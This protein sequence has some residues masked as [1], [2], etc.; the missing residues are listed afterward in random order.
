[1]VPD[2]AVRTVGVPV[3]AAMSVTWWSVK[4]KSECRCHQFNVQ[5][6]RC[7][8]DEEFGLITIRFY[9]CKDGPESDVVVDLV[10]GEDN[11]HVVG[12]GPLLVRQT[13]AADCSYQLIRG[14]GTVI[15]LQTVVLT[16]VRHLCT[17]VIEVE[18]NVVPLRTKNSPDAC[19]VV[20]I[21]STGIKSR[22]LNGSGPI[23]IDIFVTAKWTRINC[24]VYVGRVPLK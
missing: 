21:V 18:L 14:A 6:T 10:T 3:Q 11:H 9:C 19:C 13:V 22:G 12:F 1:M 23:V 5:A 16:L 4:N 17:E 20:L 8:G 2:V 24:G 7:S 15:D